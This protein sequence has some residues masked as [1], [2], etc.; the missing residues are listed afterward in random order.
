MINRFG[1]LPSGQNYDASLKAP[2]QEAKEVEAR[3]ALVQHS[4]SRHHQ[5]RHVRVATIVPERPEQR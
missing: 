2:E 5:G 3:R 1:S 4:A